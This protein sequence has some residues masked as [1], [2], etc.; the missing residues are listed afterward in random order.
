M[1]LGVVTHVAGQVVILERIEIEYCL[2]FLVKNDI[3]IK[4]SPLVLKPLFY[5]ESKGG[6]QK[7]KKEI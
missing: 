1:G 4:A 6:V 5:V 7:I 3:E 2:Y